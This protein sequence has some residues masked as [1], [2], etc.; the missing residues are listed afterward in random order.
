MPAAVP[1]IMFLSG[2]LTEEDASVYLNTMNSIN[3]ASSRSFAFSYGRA[4]QQSCLQAWQGNDI[5]A[6]Q[7]ALMARAQA[8]SEAST[9]DYVAGS[10]PS[11]QDT[12]FEAGYKY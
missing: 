10:Q 1:G 9:G 2:G 3:R 12:L 7:K 4:L 11:S 5:V 8:N 6:G